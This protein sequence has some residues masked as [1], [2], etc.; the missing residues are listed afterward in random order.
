MVAHAPA[1]PKEPP[2]LSLERYED[3]AW[4]IA[5]VVFD[6]AT[7]P[8]FDGQ[9]G[10]AKTAALVLGI[11]LHESQFHRGIDTGARL[12]DA[13]RSYCLM[14][15]KVGRGRTATWN[16]VKDR[17]A[18]PGDPEAHLVRGYTGAEMVADRK[19]CIV[20]ALRVARWSMRRK[21]PHLPVKE[22]LRGYMSGNC[23]E[24]G[25]GSRRRMGSALSWYSRTRGA[26]LFSDAHVRRE[27]HARKCSSEQS[28]VPACFSTRHTQPNASSCT[29]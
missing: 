1:D 24:G 12:G 3:I 29:D 25:F 5:T 10:R 16:V 8:S 17:E 20:A 21:C 2:P 6:P 14:Q 13:D 28:E 18:W 27:M 9:D 15:V 7:P 4:D 19:K 22:R 26:F 11:M 23:D